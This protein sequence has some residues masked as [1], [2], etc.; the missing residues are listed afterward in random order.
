MLTPGLPVVY[1][2]N[3]NFISRGIIFDLTLAQRI[4]SLWVSTKIFIL[5][6]VIILLKILKYKST[7]ANFIGG[8][9]KICIGMLL[10]LK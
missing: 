2:P 1:V 7:L 4:L 6:I 8:A 9:Q 5:S 10:T 3:I